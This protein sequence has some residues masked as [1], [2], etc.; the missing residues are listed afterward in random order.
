MRFWLGADIEFDAENVVDAVRILAQYF[1]QSHEALVASKKPSPFA[2]GRMEIRRADQ[3]LAR[4][5]F[6]KKMHVPDPPAIL[7]C[8]ICKRQVVKNSETMGSE[9][10]GQRMREFQPKAPGAPP[11]VTVRPEAPMSRPS[12]QASDEIVRGSAWKNTHPLGEDE[13]FAKMRKLAETP[14]PAAVMVCKICGFE[15]EKSSDWLPGVLHCGQPMVEEQREKSLDMDLL[16]ALFRQRG[17]EP[18]F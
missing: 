14:D 12:P 6:M 2:K 5:E 1:Q 7:I 10:H 4:Q 11:E 9:C 8:D 16:R 18:D 13:E 3:I 17:L 15:H